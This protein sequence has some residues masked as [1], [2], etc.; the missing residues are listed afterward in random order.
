MFNKILPKCRRMRSGLIALALLAG[1]GAAQAAPPTVATTTGRF[2]G[3]P[4]PSNAAVNAYLGIRYAAPP[5]GALRW[6][7]PRAPA[8][9]A[10]TV[11][12]RTRGPICPQAPTNPPQ[13]QSED[14][15]SLNVYVP[16]TALPTARLPVYVWIHGGALVSGSG[17]AYDPS[18]L[19]AENGI[20][21]VTLNYRLGAL[22]WLASPGLK[23][24]AASA[25]EGKGDSGNYGL[26]DQQFALQ[27]VQ[28][29]IAA[30]GGDPAKVTIGG[31]SAGGLSVMG[32]LVSTTTG[33]GLFRA[34]IVQSGAYMVHQLR[35]V[36]AYQ[37][38]YATAFDRA[39]SCAPGAVACLRARPVATILA[40]QKA[41]F[42]SFGIAPAWGTRILPRALDPAFQ[43]GQFIRVPIL[44]GTNAHEGRL[45]EPLLFPWLGSAATVTAAGGP[46]S[47]AMKTPNAL[48]AVVPGVPARCTYA[49]AIG[50]FLNAIG[51]PAL[52]TPTFVAQ[53][54][55]AY[56]LARFPNRYQANAASA[57]MALSQIFTDATYACTAA[58][59]NARLKGFARVF[60]YEFDDPNAPPVDG[61]PIAPPNNRHGFPSG[62]A[63]AAEL[64]FLF[65]FRAPLSSVEQQQARMMRTYWGNFVKSV[66]PNVGRAVPAWPAQAAATQPVQALVPPP[67]VTRPLATFWQQHQCQVWDPIIVW[68]NQS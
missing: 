45:F 36:G 23:A 67:A 17:S 63:H 33:R 29:N 46:A 61:P 10:G 35:S 56:P 32:H 1:A 52:N 11:V 18:A 12:A 19:V 39:A 26:M 30:F 31:E 60:A 15:L 55:A 59:A 9:P 4:S 48:C 44:H 50:I 2:T 53:L 28:R 34:A 16:A 68:Q 43:T 13:A 22:G 49:Q 14:C 65:D 6:T 38:T 27:W 41:V 47:H 37:A 25:L 64:Q 24:A 8:V 58:W 62:A 7:P 3:V 54:A 5:V 42:G 20:I 66:D 40:A 21:V 57:D 51:A